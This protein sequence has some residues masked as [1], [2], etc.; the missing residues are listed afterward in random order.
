MY[1]SC[2]VA[3]GPKIATMRSHR[4]AG[5]ITA[6]IF[7]ALSRSLVFGLHAMTINRRITRM[8]DAK[9]ILRDR[10]SPKPVAAVTTPMRV[11]TPG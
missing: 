1:G 8:S 5:T 9:V 3:S 6:D 7:V 11:C 2:E 10:I 4:T